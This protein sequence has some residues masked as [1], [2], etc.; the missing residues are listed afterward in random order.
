VLTLAQVVSAVIAF[1]ASLRLFYAFA[2][3]GAL[4]L[5]TL[6]DLEP[7]SSATRGKVYGLAS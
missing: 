6:Y 7:I 4:P 5:K 2:R 1:T 3:D